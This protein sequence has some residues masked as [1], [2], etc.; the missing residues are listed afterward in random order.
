MLRLAF[1]EELS[2]SGPRGHG[3][4][5]DALGRKVF[6]HDA[7]HLLNGTFGGI[8]EKISW[9]NRGSG[10]LSGG[11]QDDVGAFGHVRCCFL[12]GR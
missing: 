3:V 10:A 6:A 9:L 4:D 11:E 12:R 2:A 8:V 5:V 7:G 1:V